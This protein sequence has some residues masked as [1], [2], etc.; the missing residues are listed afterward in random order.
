MA[1]KKAPEG[2][3]SH[4]RWLVSYADFI[5]L[6]FAFFVVMFAASNMN[7]KRREDAE[8]AFIAAFESWG[9]FTGAG[10]PNVIDLEGNGTN[11][12]LRINPEEDP[13][14]PPTTGES[15]QENQRSNG[16]THP[17]GWK[18]PQETPPPGPNQPGE[19]GIGTEGSATIKA[20]FDNLQRL[21]EKD[22]SENRISMALEKR[23]IVVTLSDANFSSQSSADLRN[24][25]LPIVDRIAGKLL[26]LRKNN[27]VVRVEGHTDN[28]PL[29]PGGRYRDN[30]ELSVARAT[31]VVYR[32]LRHGFSPPNLVAS[33]YGQWRPID[34]NETNEGRAR[35]RR[36]D[37]VI[38]SDEFAVL[39][40]KG[41]LMA[42]PPI[43]LP[44]VTQVSELDQNEN[45][46]QR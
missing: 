14:L 24:E 20:F 33:G 4:E 40:P 32:L 7:K 26:A 29:P 37:L 38:L 16:A 39:E 34:T 44:D 13:N 30:L 8:K 17:E 43:P 22:L 19:Q 15:E 36:V 46:A 6:L 1:R 35:N 28:T 9:I 18:T 41:R 42:P 23:G 5:T 27:I 25:A 21:L 11:P 2:H 3:V 10:R 45:R 12:A 31:S